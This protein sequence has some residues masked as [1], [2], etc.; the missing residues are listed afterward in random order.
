M[1]LVRLPAALARP[2]MIVS[3]IARPRRRVTAAAKVA[4]VTNVLMP[5]G[6][7]AV[8]PGKVRTIARP[9]VNV[10][11]AT[12]RASAISRVL[13]A[14]RAS[15]TSPVLVTSVPTA[16]VQPIAARVWIALLR[17][18]RSGPVR[19]ARALILQPA[20]IGQNGR[21]ARGK[22]MVRHAATHVRHL[23]LASALPTVATA[24]RQIAAHRMPPVM[25][26]IAQKVIV[27]KGVARKVHVPKAAVHIQP[28]L[29]NRASVLTVPRLGIASQ[30][31]VKAHCASRASWLTAARD[32]KVPAHGLTARTPAA[33]A[34]KVLDAQLVE[35]ALSAPVLPAAAPIAPV[36]GP[37]KLR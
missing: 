26:A 15:V 12:N 6:K 4:A 34:A 30:V 18:V 11:A 23:P 31:V 10:I 9:A 20:Q 33:T 13:A 7:A 27:L 16:A 17:N 35:K 14:N 1:T 29:T 25:K 19:I 8:R 21:P 28:A 22:R 24:R 5:H 37:N 36:T 32:R 2:L 3:G